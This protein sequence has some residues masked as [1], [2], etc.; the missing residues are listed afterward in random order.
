MLNSKTKFFITLFAFVLSI[1]FVFTYVNATNEV[2]SISNTDVDNSLRRKY[3][4]R[5]LNIF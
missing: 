2:M 5:I 3:Y 1:S 4:S